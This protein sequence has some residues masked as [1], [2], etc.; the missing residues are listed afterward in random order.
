M[1]VPSQEVFRARLDGSWTAWSGAWQLCLWQG[2]SNWIIFKFP[3]TPSHSM[4]HSMILWCL[5]EICVFPWKIPHFL[6]HPAERVLLRLVDLIFDRWTDHMRA[7]TL[8]Q[9]LPSLGF[10][11]NGA[12]FGYILVTS[13]LHPAFSGLPSVCTPLSGDSVDAVTHRLWVCGMYSREQLWAFLLLP[14]WRGQRWALGRREL[15]AFLAGLE[16]WQDSALFSIFHLTATKHSLI[17]KK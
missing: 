13:P 15:A 12:V 10:G 8:I 16:L 9:P 17:T 4:M 3:S 11:P 2:D 7:S 14:V 5:S 1:D 6:F